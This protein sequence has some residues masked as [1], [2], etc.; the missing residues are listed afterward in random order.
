M[1]ARRAKRKLA[2]AQARTNRGDAIVDAELEKS[3][4]KEFAQWKAKLSA[5]VSEYMQN[6]E[7]RAST[8]ALSAQDSRELK[9]LHRTLGNVQFLRT[10]TAE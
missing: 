2:L 1:E 5:H 10:L 4:Q 6:L 9:K 7:V 8:T 3:L